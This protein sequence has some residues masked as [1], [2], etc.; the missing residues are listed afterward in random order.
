MAIFGRLIIAVAIGSGTFGM[1]ANE[2]AANKGGFFIT[3]HW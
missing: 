2:K 1:A 3:W